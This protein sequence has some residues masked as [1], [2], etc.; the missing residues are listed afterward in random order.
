M[1]YFNKGRAVRKRLSLWPV[2]N[3]LRIDLL[4]GIEEQLTS[5]YKIKEHF[6]RESSKHMKQ[7]TLQEMYQ[8]PSE[9][10]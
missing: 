3:A 5:I 9:Q 10:A 6:P 1:L 8:N 4:C 2:R 7:L